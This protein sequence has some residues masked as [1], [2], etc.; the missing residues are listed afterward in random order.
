MDAHIFRR[1]APELAAALQGARVE[2]VHCP[3][4]GCFTFTLGS[5][6]GKRLLLF[7]P[8]APGHGDAVLYL[9]ADR[10]NRPENPA[11]PPAVAMWLRK[12]L[13]GRRI[14]GHQLDWPGRRLA[15]ELTPSSQGYGNYL[16]LDLAQDPTVLATLDPAFGQEPQWPTLEQ[17]LG[18]ERVWQEYPHISP[19][20]RRMLRALPAEQAGAAY[21]ELRRGPAPVVYVAL[22]QR[23]LQGQPQSLTA[24]KPT[25]AEEVREYSSALEAARAYGEPTFFDGVKATVS[26][27]DVQARKVRDKKHGRA[28]ARLAQDRERLA[29]MLELQPQAEALQAE[30]Y[31]YAEGPTPQRLTLQHPRSG[32]LT[33]ELNTHLS[34]S[35]NMQAMFKAVAKGKRGLEAVARREVQLAAEAKAPP[36]EPAAPRNQPAKPA[37]KGKGTGK[38]PV[39]GVGRFVSSDGFTML[40]GKSQEANHKLL[41]HGASAFDYWLHA[42]GRSGAHVILKRDHP[43]QEVPERTLEQ[44][45]ILA[46]LS[47]GYA[48]EAK[49]EVMCA[50]V[51]D[52]RKIKGAA[53]G[54]VRVEEVWRTLRVALDPELPARLAETAGGAEG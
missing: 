11:V 47:S 33:V 30:L 35:E 6:Q 2:K 1:L 4:R 31:K 53:L 12:R 9:S 15:L 13:T 36:A 26:A 22:R 46:G 5:H 7:R 17:V 10:A 27:P 44:A 16:L 8:A 51:K 40:R 23:Q 21:D 34:V 28:Q 19:P 38:G 37:A 24:W 52:V 29:G 50:L 49:A 14:L 41:S 42:A 3:V 18:D 48:G 54:L 25:K 32:E 43:A 20:L 39:K 45:A